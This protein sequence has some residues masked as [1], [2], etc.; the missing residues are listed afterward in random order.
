MNFAFELILTPWGLLVGCR[1][2]D[3]WLCIQVKV[4]VK[5]D[6]CNGMI[7]TSFCFRGH[8]VR[9]E[10]DGAALLEVTG[11][12]LCASDEQI[13]ESICDWGIMIRYNFRNV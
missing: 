12:K 11:D 13:Y 5:L 9:R 1:E 6:C 4:V 2:G 8:G 7:A 10:T 3:T